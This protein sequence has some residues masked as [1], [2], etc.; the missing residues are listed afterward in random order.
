MSLDKHNLS[1]E[2]REFADKILKE[3]WEFVEGCRRRGIKQLEGLSEEEKEIL[4]KL[5]EGFREKLDKLLQ[6]YW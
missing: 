4:N 3:V 1:E 6:L 2:C 5:P